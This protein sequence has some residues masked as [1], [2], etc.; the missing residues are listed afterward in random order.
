MDAQDRLYTLIPLTDFK[1][2][3]GIDDRELRLRLPM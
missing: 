2:A 3:L 1:A